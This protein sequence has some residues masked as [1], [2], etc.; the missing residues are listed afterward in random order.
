MKFKKLASLLKEL[1]KTNSRIEIRNEIKNF[2]KESD[3]IEKTIY[4]LQGELFRPYEGIE[5]NLSIKTIEK[6]IAD[7]FGFTR[8]KVVE[9][10][11]KLGDM[12]LVTEELANIKKQHSLFNKSLSL[13]DVYESLRKI[14][15]TDGKDSVRLKQANI[16]SLLQNT[17]PNEAKYII[18][19]ILGTLR[20]SLGIQ[21][22]IE[23]LVLFQLE[24]E[25]IENYKENMQRFN[26]IK[27]MIDLKFNITNDLG[28]IAKTLFKNG[29][30]DVEKVTLIPGIPIKSALCEREKD[31]ESIIKR[32]GKCL[33]ETKY[34]GFRAQIH[35][36]KNEIKMFSRRSE[37]I[38]HLFPEFVEIFRKI[39]DDFIID[40]EAVGY[41]PKTKKLLNFQETIQR[42]RKYDIKE[43]AAKI[44][45]NFYVFDIMYFNNETFQLPL[46]ER[47]KLVKNLCKK[48]NNKNVIISNAK[49]VETQEEL[50]L[51]FDK[52]LEIGAEG[53]IAK[54]LE[55]P[56]SPG[57]RGFGW[58]KLKKNYLT[59]EYDSLDLTIIGYF[60]GKGKNAN[61]P[62]SVLLAVY[63]SNNDQYKAI[64]KMGSGLT[65]QII[66]DFDKEF[67]NIKLDNKPT[68][69]LT[70]LKPDFYIKPKIIVEVIYDEITL[71]PLYKSTEKGYSLRFP[72]LFNIR[73]DRAP[74]DTSTEDEIEK[75]YELQKK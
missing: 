39:D 62:S 51:E 30:N 71:S 65:E 33:V 74:T 1:E 11:K 52:N 34:D 53:I 31:A 70:D 37:N 27:E 72:R 63:D 55:K 57:G 15:R 56:Y 6:S 23:S 13:N 59:G 9:N 50:K 29:F 54:D 20:L 36:S 4:L 58:I 32:L 66:D 42:R 73:E 60:I 46:K 24:K 67:E 8:E 68:N 14:A 17:N 69:Y 35:K 26:E 12:G 28:F 40:C 61:K 2:L 3:N 21:T 44:P 41:N 48:I 16:V 38:T 22:I 43:T 18:K 64:A 5:L 49:I 47:R 10:Y 7:A 19:I 25:G 75:L 45:I